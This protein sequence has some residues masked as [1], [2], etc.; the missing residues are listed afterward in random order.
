V[1]R[2]TLDR[3]T[4][5][6]GS[7]KALDGVGLDVADGEFLAVLGPSGCGKTTLLRLVAGFD[8]LD[9]GEIRIGDR[10]V[11]TRAGHIPPEHRRVGIVFQN[12]ALWPHMTVA[13]NV[14]YSLR[15]AG[16][17]VAERNKRV[18]EA[19]ELV[20]LA[21]FGDR[22]PALLSG[23][24]RQRVALARCLVAAPSLVLLDEPLANLD[25]HLRASMEDEFADFHRR[26]GTTMIYITHDQ[27]EAMALADRIAVMDQGRLMQLA[28]PSELYREPATA[29]VA[30]FIGHGMVVP[31]TDIAPGGGG[32][33]SASFIG[34]R[35]A[36]RCAA[37]QQAARS[38]ALCVRAG[39]LEIAP[40]GSGGIA[41][42]VTRVVYRGGLFH[43]EA[44]AEMAP[45]VRL[46][47][48]VP[49]PSSVAVGDAVAIAVKPGG[50]WVIPEPERDTA[51]AAA[52][53]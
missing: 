17:S 21:G 5:I 3:V 51:P 12:Y 4:K 2:L 32:R 30:S 38:G 39:D 22:R 40:A 29:M 19:L 20:D 53:E 26:T 37:G 24:Q 41:C 8:Q 27:A 49:E 50:G 47:L 6:F 44:V 1:A 18:A 25:V 31:I 9:E 48:D 15:V 10:P 46:W 35:I 33:A 23:G 13:E 45:D 36:A 34:Q 11:S 28:T 16:V 14:G 52:A 7:Y 43:V 42:R